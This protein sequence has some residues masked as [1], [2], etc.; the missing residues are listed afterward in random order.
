MAFIVDNVWAYYERQD[1]TRDKVTALQGQ[2]KETESAINN[3]MSAIEAGMPLTEMT[4][5]RLTE[6]DA[7]RTAISTALAGTQLESGFRLQKDHIQ[8]FL[9]QFRDL[10]YSDPKCQQRLID[11]FVN[12]I[13]VKDDELII[14]FN[15]SGGSSTLTF[16]DFKAADDAGVFGCRALLST[17]T[18]AYELV[19]YANVFA[20]VTKAPVR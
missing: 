10:D 2:L 18:R 4:K 20:L 16:T 12:S 3:L 7:Q 6:L 15:F 19:F 8:F 13:F 9:E 1:K 17:I 14:N 11:V 5:S